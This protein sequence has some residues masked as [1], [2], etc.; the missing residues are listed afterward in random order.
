MKLQRYMQPHASSFGTTG[1]ES[2]R[3]S[4]MRPLESLSRRCPVTGQRDLKSSNATSIGHSWECTGDVAA[5][6]YTSMVLPEAMSRPSHGCTVRVCQVAYKV[7]L[8][9]NHAMQTGA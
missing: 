9:A 3:F 6:T 5:N 1:L 4:F 7:M 8:P 2:E